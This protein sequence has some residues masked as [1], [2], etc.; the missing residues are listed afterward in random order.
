M[1]LLDG[2]RPRETRAPAL[3]IQ[4]FF[5]YMSKF[6]GRRNRRQLMLCHW[7]MQK[8][9]KL[10]TFLWG[11][12]QLQ[13]AGCRLNA[14]CM[15]TADHRPKTADCRPQ[16]GDCRLQTANCRVQTA[17]CKP[18]TENWR[19]VMNNIKFPR[20]CNTNCGLRTTDGRQGVKCRLRVKSRWQ[21][22]GKM[23]ARGK[24]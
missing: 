21:T 3:L 4:K 5:Q 12:R 22:K 10:Y 11:V 17:E 24:M 15:Q 23:Q 13:T 14:D 16:T 18:L 9:D 20:Q 6:Y 8:S 1:A 7:M 2:T 19:H